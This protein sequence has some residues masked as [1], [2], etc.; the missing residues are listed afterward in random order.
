MTISLL[1][2]LPQQNTGNISATN[3]RLAGL[4]GTTS[5]NPAGQVAGAAPMGITAKTPTASV[6]PAPTTLPKAQQNPVTPSAP[7]S[8]ANTLPPAPVA[9]QSN[10]VVPSNATYSSGQDNTGGNTQGNYTSINPSGVTIYGNGGPTA[11]TG[12]L[13]QAAQNAPTFAG[14]TGALTSA[15]QQG[16]GAAQGYTAQTANYGAGNIP[17]GQ[18]AQQIA[19]DYGQ[20]IANIGGQGARFESGQLTTGTS[21][22]AQG[23]AAITAQSTAAQQQALATGESAALQGIGYQLTGQNQAANASNEAAGQAQTGQGLLQSGLQQ[24]GVLSQPSATASGQTTFNPLTGSFTGGSGQNDPTQAPS[25]YTQADWSTIVNNVANGVPNA[26][27]GLPTVL[28][29]QAQAAAHAQN[30]NFNYATAVGQAAGQQAVGAAGGQAQASNIQT[31]GTAGTAG[32]A[33][34]LQ[35]TIGTY[36]NMSALNTTADQQAKTVQ[37]VLQSTGLNQGVPAFTKPLNTLSGQL[38]SANVTA[39]TSAVTEMQNVYSQLLSS[40]GTTPS[41]SEAQALALLSPNS[42]PA[43]INSAIQQLQTAAYNKLSGQY[44]QLQ[45]EQ[46]ALQ[47]G[48]GGSTGNTTNTGTVQTAIGE[49]NTNW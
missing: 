38:G 15:A 7:V 24:A 23:N 27:S 9:P 14:T 43:Q 44:S 28:Q 26:I 46:N 22:V 39:L 17:I 20:K 19:N 5:I 1:G 31:A 40:G 13:T 16:S 4:S 34:A 49:I 8:Q 25:G 21:P 30:P 36:N 35:G 29:A 33:S 3:P 41:G 6:T 37:Q 11:N 2:A 10:Y 42:T 48:T 45:T 47:S 32:T 18:E 12:L